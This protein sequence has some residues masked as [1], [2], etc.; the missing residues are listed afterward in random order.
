[1]GDDPT[2]VAL[3]R[4]IW[5][6]VTV[7]V[8][9][10]AVCLLTFLA[11]D[12][13]LFF[14]RPNDARAVDALRGHAWRLETG[15]A[16]LTGWLRPADDPPNAALILYFGGNAED[17]AMTAL[18]SPRHAN[19][20]YVNYRG[21]GGTAGRPSETALIQDA[22]AVY[23]AASA[24]VAHNGYILAIGRSLGSGV[25]VQLAARRTLR[26]LVLITPFDSLVEVARAH[27]P[28][29]PVRTLLKHR[30]ES[31]RVAPSLEIPAL[32][33]IAGQDRIIPAERG[34][35]LARIW[36]GDAIVWHFAAANHNDIDRA[37]G[38]ERA[39]EDFLRNHAG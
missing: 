21:Y 32:L 33:L 4:I 3:S 38:Y 22:L 16:T 15:A 11:Q 23:D 12:R 17:V 27:Y 18:G 1:V 29:L 26:A 7:I 6:T 31:D 20:L 37:E 39:L 5:I 34:L 35:R 2:A 9:Y 13:M 24:G 28:W 19:H 36:G 10:G 30:F 8:A 25:A 14:P